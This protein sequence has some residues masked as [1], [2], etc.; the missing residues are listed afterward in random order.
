M[1]NVKIAGVT[2]E[3]VPEVRLQ[4]AA[5]PLETVAFKE[6]AGSV[7]ISENGTYDVS[8]KASA[9]V[10][11]PSSGGGGDPEVLFYDY[12]GTVLHSYSKSE[13]MA[14]AAMP[15]NPTHEGL[16]AHGWNYTLA[17]AKEQ[18]EAVGACDIGQMYTTDTG[19]TRIYIT[20]DDDTPTNR[21]KCYIRLQVWNRGDSATIDWGDGD[22]TS[23]TD[24]AVADY[25]HT[26]AATGSYVIKLIPVSGKIALIG[27]GSSDTSGYSVYGS[28]DKDNYASRTLVRK[29]EIGDNVAALAYGYFRCCYRLETITIPSGLDPKD[30]VFVKC[31][32]LKHLTLPVGCH[33]DNIGLS[34]CMELKS[35]SIPYQAD[36][37]STIDNC[38][39]LKRLVYSKNITRIAYTQYCKALEHVYFADTAVYVGA[40]QECPCLKSFKTPSGVTSLPNDFLKNC[41]AL[42]SVTIPDGILQIQG[43]AFYGCASLKKVD[44]PEGLKTISGSAFNM[45]GLESIEIPDGVTSI[46]AGAFTSCIA[47][48]TAVLPS[49][50]T[51]ITATLFMNCYSLESVNIPNGVTSIMQNAFR[52][53]HS[54]KRVDIPASV[55]SISQSAFYNCYGVGEY[56]IKATTPPTLGS[57]DVFTGIQS[58]CKIYVPAGTFADYQAATNWSA[59]ASYMVEEAT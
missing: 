47:L 42:E 49:G 28:R 7:A 12:D 29:V 1:A 35:I 11:V 19:E 10:N 13:F 53:C 34:Y 15:A 33:Y 3:G 6:C 27:Q 50:I 37:S 46:G 8:G 57:S 32:A 38:H 25:E 55:T 14:L 56:H 51:S 2:Y 41:S 58:D 44:L 24:T 4:D 43:N 21:L 39:S 45:S 18:L 48:K 5:D 54:L 36:S 31:Y 17:Q 23:V 20:F 26:Y 16:T 59:Y 30:N 22:T 52:E 9:V 40:H